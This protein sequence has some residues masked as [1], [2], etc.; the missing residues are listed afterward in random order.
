MRLLFSILILLTLSACQ[1][2]R[3]LINESERG[4]ASTANRV[5]V[6][7]GNASR[8]IESPPKNFSNGG[9]L[10]ESEIEELKTFLTENWSSLGPNGAVAS[11]LRLMNQTLRGSVLYVRFQQVFARKILGRVYYLPLEGAD[12]IAILQNGRLLEIHSNLKNPPE[13]KFQRR[14]SGFQFDFSDNEMAAFI[15]HAKT[16][17]EVRATFRQNLEE[18]ARRSSQTFEFDLFLNREVAEQREILNRLFAKIGPKATARNLVQFTV[19]GLLSLVPFKDQWILQIDGAFG[20]PMQFDIIVPK[21]SET[22]FKFRHLRDQRIHSQVI[23]FTS[24]HFP[25]GKKLPDG[26]QA[27]IAGAR[28]RSVADYFSR[29]HDWPSYQGQK[30]DGDIVIHTQLKSI[31]FKENAAWL[32]QRKTFVVGEGGTSVANLNASV[33]VLGHEYTHAIVQFS[34]ALTYKGESGAINEHIADI[35]GALIDSASK[36]GGFPYSIGADVLTPQIQK[37]RSKL[38][39]LIFSEYKFSATEINRYN[40]SQPSLRNFYAPV[41]SFAT[42]VSSLGEYRKLYPS[43]C[44]PSID[45]D[46]CGVHSGSGLLNR[47]ASLIIDEIGLPAARKLFFNTAIYRLNSSSSFAQYREQLLQECQAMP[48]IAGKCAVIATSFERVGVDAQPSQSLSSQVDKASSESKLTALIAGSP[49]LKFCGW[50]DHPSP[51]RL[52]ILDGKYDANVIKRNFPVKTAGD[53]RSLAKLECACATGRI[54]QVTKEDGQIFNGFIEVTR[55]DDRQNA[56]AADPALANRKPRIERPLPPRPSEPKL[57]C[58]WVS[59][60]S[61][62]RNITII[63]NRYDVAILASGYKTLTAGDYAELPKHQCA[64]VE[65]QVTQTENSKGTTFNYFSKLT[66][67]AVRPRPPEACVEIQWK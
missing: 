20:I 2:Q 14:Q 32:G 48:D 21:G 25:G 34:S 55:I 31:D 67:Q 1:T 30:V 65:G 62:S 39:E 22:L 51:D 12:L 3:P 27:Q 64:C 15:S 45:N 4:L 5:L 35:Q 40:L 26:D 36:G 66:L 37:E 38:A 41:L 47:A 18:V 28:M 8:D 58:G 56:C 61:K 13:F 11:T 53:Y 42:Q 16:S 52:M 7:V 49:S 6:R 63:D 10:P 46:N 17:E 9:R 19:D 43:D 54:T 44:Q 57:F 24:P 29:G 60:N 59:V 33:G 23:S 50:V